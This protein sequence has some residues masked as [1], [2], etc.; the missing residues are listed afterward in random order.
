MALILASASPRRRQLLRRLRRP[1]KV[2]PS[3]VPEESREKNPRRLVLLLAKRKALEIARKNPGD[4]VIGADTTVYCGGEILNKP[5]G[6]D[7]ALRMLML[8]SGRWQRVYTGVAV[9]ADGGRRLFAEATV[10]RVKCRTLTQEQLRRFARKH[11]D[12]AGAYAAQDKKDPFVE[13]V[14]GPKDNVVGLPVESV[15][16]LLRRLRSSQ[17]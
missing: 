16:R 3:R 14:V 13:R 10:S 4:V 5:A 15:R 11:L 8:Q 12:K 2:V 17:G 1:F 9:A 6:V 7:D